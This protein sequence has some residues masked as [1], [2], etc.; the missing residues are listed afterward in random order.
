MEYKVKVKLEGGEIKTLKK[1]LALRVEK[2]GLGK[3]VKPGKK[4][5]KP[6]AKRKTKEN[7]DVDKR[8]KK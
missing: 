7:K 6:V 1:T 4:Q 3:I 8:V 5:S 2:Q